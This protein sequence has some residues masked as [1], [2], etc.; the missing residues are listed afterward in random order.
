MADLIPFFIDLIPFF[1]LGILPSLVWLFYFLE[2]DNDPEP[3][4][5][6]VLVFFLGVFGA[7]LAA[8]IQIP[9]REIIY[10]VDFFSF[11][12]RFD[13]AELEVFLVGFIDSFFLVAFIEES[14]KLLAVLAGVFLLNKRELDEPVDCI[15][16][17]VT[18][19]LGFAAL[20]NFLYFSE[21]PLEMV[22]ELVLL[23]FAITTLFHALAAGILGYFI[24]LSI[25]KMKLNLVF[26]GLLTVTFFHTLYNLLIS[27]MVQVEGLIYPGLLLGF[28]LLLTI[29]LMRAFKRC[30]EMK[31]ICKPAS[32]HSD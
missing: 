2:K 10:S 9:T 16:Y 26:L 6:I 13:M 21:A 1:I 11:L 20:E 23:R 32:L 30:K 24:A 17:M 27:F 28:L 29:V 4:I 3:K 5:M 31:S 18:A 22:T 25:K 7:F 15:I 8:I 14:S 19:G 12:E